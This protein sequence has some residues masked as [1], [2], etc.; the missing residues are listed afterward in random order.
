MD[1]TH[2]VLNGRACCSLGVLRM[3]V[4]RRVGVCL[5]RSTI[6]PLFPCFIP[7]KG[8]MLISAKTSFMWI[9]V[10]VI[11][12]VESSLARILLFTES[13]HGPRPRMGCHP[14]RFFFT[15]QL[16]YGTTDLDQ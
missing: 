16:P 5:T 15:S 10:L 2:L 3:L 1:V 7:S 6:N 8:R 14:I 9:D 4:G 11:H 12:L 13:S